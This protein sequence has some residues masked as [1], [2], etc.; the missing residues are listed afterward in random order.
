MLLALLSRWIPDAAL[1]ARVLVD[2]AAELY[3]FD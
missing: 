3:G 1:R 2:N